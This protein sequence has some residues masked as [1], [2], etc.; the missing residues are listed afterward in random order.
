MNRLLKKLN[1][2]Q[3][4]PRA[5]FKLLLEGRVTQEEFLLY[6]L[7]VAIT[8]W[9][10]RH[11]TYGTFEATNQELAEPLGW[12]S[13]TTA[14]THKKSLIRKN[15]FIVVDGNRIKAKGFDKWQLRTLNPSKNKDETAEKQLNTSKI[16]DKPSEI[17][18][19]LSQNN[20]YSLVSS[21]V[22]LSLNESVNEDLSNKELMQIISDIDSKGLASESDPSQRFE[23]GYAN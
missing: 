21:K 8:D 10:P 11:E 7:A 13:D 9:D 5:R 2:Y 22:D 6:E 15:L 20:D 19:N 17:K 18:K 16:E 1:G 12:K 23:E 14:L 3:K 4:A